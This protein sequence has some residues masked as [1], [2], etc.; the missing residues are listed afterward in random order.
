MTANL[1]ENSDVSLVFFNWLSAFTESDEFDGLTDAEKRV[2]WDME[3]TLESSLPAIL[4]DDYTSAV[5]AASGRIL[6]VTE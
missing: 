1:F 4:A 6:G 2:M 3:A 5:D